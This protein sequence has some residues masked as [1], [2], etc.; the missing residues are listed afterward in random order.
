MLKLFMFAL[1]VAAGQLAFKY[2]ARGLGEV[3]GFGPI[4]RH[5]AFNP[6]FI[7]ALALYGIATLLWIL[8]LRE[9]PLSKAY[10]FIALAFALVPIGAAIFFEESLGIRYCVGLLLVI[11]GVMVI[12]SSNAAA[13]SNRQAAHAPY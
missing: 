10:V 2:V 1:I 4:L 11:A 7:G 5:L 9:M 3:A 12:G 6:W 8:T 13:N